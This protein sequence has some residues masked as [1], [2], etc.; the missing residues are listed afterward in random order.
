MDKPMAFCIEA[1]TNVTNDLKQHEKETLLVIG[2]F[3]SVLAVPTAAANALV[4]VAILT[5]SS[6]RTPSY[7]LLTSL[8]FSDLAVGLLGQPVFSATIFLYMN[9]KARMYCHIRMIAGSLMAV[10]SI[11][12]LFTM[13]GISVDRYLAIRLKLKY[14]TLVTLRRIRFF[15]VGVWALTPVLMSLSY[16]I[17]LGI[18]SFLGAI[19]VAICLFVILYC[20]IMSFR[21]L[22]IYCAQIQTQGNQ[23]PNETSN[24]SDINVRKYKKL[25]KTMLLVL[26]ITGVFCIPLLGAMAMFTKAVL[27]RNVAW[28]CLRIST[29][30]STLNPVIYFTR[31]KDLR[32]ACIRILRKMLRLSESVPSQERGQ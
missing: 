12:V 23:Q 26:A 10:L 4:I 32:Q 21:T 29:L 13:L 18:M 11:A 16:F 25:L 17:S 30:N 6:L 19:T 3:N 7:L 2:V 27:N 24:S 28:V 1:V 5:T 14:K 20:Y 22:K 31:M 15:L 8:A 9:R